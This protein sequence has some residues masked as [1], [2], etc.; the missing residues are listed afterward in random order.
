M[1]TGLVQKVAKVILLKEESW[2]TRL[3]I[4]CS[5]WPDEIQLGESICTSGCCLTVSEKQLNNEEIEISFDVIPETLDCTTLGSLLSGSK[6]NIER[7]LRSDSLLG[8]HFV[9]GHVDGVEE[10]LSI[11][12]EDDESR[13]R[14]SMDSIDTDTIVAKGSVTIDGV[15]LTIAS[16]GDSCFEVALI[17]TTLRE[18]TLGTA[19][20]GSKLNIETD[21]LARTVVNVVRT[22]Q[23]N[24]SVG[25]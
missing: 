19:R 3:V 17:P 16:V 21:I 11:S 24:N 6:V 20:V 9:Q 15:S 10:I 22:M 14:I 2:G 4:S 7:S 8:G 12:S 18:T 25:L 23:Q 5:L 13:L 1:F